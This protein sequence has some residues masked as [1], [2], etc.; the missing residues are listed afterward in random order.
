MGDAIHNVHDG[1][2]LVP[3]FLVSPVVGFG[4]AL[5]IL[6]HETVQEIAEFFILLGAG[7]SIKKALLLNLIVST[8]NYIK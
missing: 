6:F 4:T 1:I 3:A 8:T 2:I 5:A 7:Y